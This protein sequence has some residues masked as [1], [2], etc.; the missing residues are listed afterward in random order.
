MDISWLFGI[1][2]NIYFFLLAYSILGAGIKYIDSAFDELTANKTIAMV[3][4]PLLGI[5]WAYTM[6][7][8]AFSATILLAVMLG[9]LLKGKLDNYAHILGFSVIVVIITLAKVELMILPLIFLSAAAVLDELGNDTT[10][11]NTKHVKNKKFRDRLALY[12]FGRRYML[13]AAVLF[14]VLIN[15][16]PMFYLLAII[17][18]DEAYI[19]MALYSHSKQKKH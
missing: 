16:F 3:L 11:N 17:F 10:D 7:L 14:L 18:F 2:D 8:N 6:V 4:A 13:K 15:V 5:L 12:F 9:V 1:K 19:M